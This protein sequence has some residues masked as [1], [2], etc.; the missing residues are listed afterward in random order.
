MNIHFL[1]IYTEKVFTVNNLVNFGYVCNP[2]SRT[3][4]KLQVG[5]YDTQ[6]ST[7]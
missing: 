1:C 2:N 4:Q 6:E 5:Q 7:S 3:N